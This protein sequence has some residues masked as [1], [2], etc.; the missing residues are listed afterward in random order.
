MELSKMLNLT[1]AQIK[2]WFQNRRTKWK[3]QFST[4]LKIVNQREMLLPAANS[5]ALSANHPLIRSY[6]PS[7]SHAMNLSSATN[8]PT[9]SS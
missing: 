9:Q 3:K 4:R 5:L 8:Y 6:Y 7:L 1:E 2:T